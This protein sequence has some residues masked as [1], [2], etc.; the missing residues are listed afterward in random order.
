MHKNSRESLSE[1]EEYALIGYPQTTQQ[2]CDVLE[3]IVKAANC[4]SPALLDIACG[5]GR[6]ALEMSRR[7][8]CVTGVDISEDMV[9]VARENAAVANLDGRFDVR[10]MRT[11]DFQARFDIAYILFNTMGLLTSNEDVLAFLR[12][13]Y[14]ALLPNGLFVFQV[15]NLWS[16]IAEGNFSNSVYESEDE[17]EGVKRHLRMQMVVGPY[18]NIYRMHYDKRYWR[19]GVELNSKSEDVDLRIF[20]LHELDL[21][22]E[23]S[24]F[25][26]LRVFGDTTLNSVIE[27]PNQICAD[28]KPYKSYVVLSMKKR[29]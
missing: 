9:N 21:L 14:E 23:L 10:D 7:G 13:T 1:A 15:G 12:S 2:D 25:K 11:L 6:H 16:Y 26:C 5:T 20:S 29:R 8:Y 24:G 19:D 18:N 22:L 4:V 28:E 3:G 27:D 17:N